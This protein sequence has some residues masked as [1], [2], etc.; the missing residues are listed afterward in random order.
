VDLSDLQKPGKESYSD[1]LNKGG[2]PEYLREGD[3]TRLHEL[4]KDVLM[5]DIANR[6]GVKNTTILRKLAIYLI[7]RKQ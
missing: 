1:Y 4:T 6:F 3:V 2:F 7:K 5:R